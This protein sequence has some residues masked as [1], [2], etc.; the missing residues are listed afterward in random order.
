MADTLFK[1]GD[2]T[3][4]RTLPHGFWTIDRRRVVYRM[5]N[6]LTRSGLLSQVE[7]HHAWMTQETR[8]EDAFNSEE[9]AKEALGAREAERARSA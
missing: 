5:A 2:G 1:M 3:V 4:I 9:K 6:K 8:Y 7:R